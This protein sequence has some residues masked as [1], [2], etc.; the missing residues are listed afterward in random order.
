MPNWTSNICEISGSVDNVKKFLDVITVHNTD[1]NEV[2]YDLT[3]CNPLPKI[4][5]TM[6]S[7]SRTIDDVRYN[8]WFED[9]DGVRP[10]LEVNALQI[11]EEYG[12]SDPLD[13]QY[14]NW[15]TKWGDSDTKITSDIVCEDT[16]E[17]TLVYDSPWNEP[18]MLLND[19]ALK[20]DLKI[21][22]TWDIEMMENSISRYPIDSHEDVYEEFRQN[23]EDMKMTVKSL[24]RKEE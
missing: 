9:E 6:H 14:R 24:Y 16:R 11:T 5:Q 4:F 13:W 23:H 3:K 20:Y 18:W 1:T 10:L 8:N 7:G 2:Y 19:I 17:I 22:N 12:C 21:S 15:G